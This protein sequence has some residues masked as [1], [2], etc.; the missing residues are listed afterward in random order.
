VADTQVEMVVYLA[1]LVLS[2]CLSL[3]EKAWKQYD[4]IDGLPSTPS[5]CRY[6][7]LRFFAAARASFSL[8]RSFTIFFTSEAG[9]DLSALKR[10][11]PLEVL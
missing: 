8:I 4:L 7:H 9:R 2:S 1:D 6:P 10:M 11:A 3:E 5:I